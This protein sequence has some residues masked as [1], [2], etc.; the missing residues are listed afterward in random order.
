[1]HPCC[2]DYHDDHKVGNILERDF[3]SI[4]NGKEMRDF[5]KKLL[6]DEDIPMCRDCPGYG[7]GKAVTTLTRKHPEKGLGRQVEDK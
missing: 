2:H 7:V 3:E 4:W 5:R 6:S 1:M